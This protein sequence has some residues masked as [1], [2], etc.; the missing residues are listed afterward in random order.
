MKELEL[1][2]QILVPP[3]VFANSTQV[4]APSLTAQDRAQCCVSDARSTVR[5][6]WGGFSAYLPAD[7]TGL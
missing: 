3:K 7:A 2:V 5:L 4:R 6:V 1:G